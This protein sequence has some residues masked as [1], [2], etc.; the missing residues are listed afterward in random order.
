MIRDLRYAIRSLRQN[1]GF[2]LVAIISLA[3]GIGA[4]AAIFSMADAFVL[5][6]MPVPHPADIVTVESQVRGEGISGLFSFSELSYPDFKDYR[7]R[8]TSFAGLTAMEYSTFGF[9]A[10]PGATPSMKFGQ[11]VTG[12]F[13]QVM[14]VTP[15]LGRGFLPQEDQVEG[16]DAVVVLSHELWKSDFASSPD[17]I[18]RTVFLNNLAFTVVGVAPESFTGPNVLL[19]S[20]LYIP[21]S[22]EVA[23]AATPDQ[24]HREDRSVRG[25]EVQGRLKPG[26][27]VAAAA[28][29]ARLI[30]EQLAKAYPASNRTTSLIV[31]T[32]LRAR[33]HQDSFD[34]ILMGF[35]MALSAVVLLIACANVMNLTL[36]RARGRSREIAVRLAI[37]AGRGR[38]IRQFLTESLVIALLGA[39]AGLLVA[40]AGVG[41]FSQL[42]IPTDIPVIVDLRIDPRVLLFSTFMA[43]G[44]AVVFGLAPALQSTHPDLVPALKS[45]RADGGKRYRFLGRNALV[46]AQVAGSLVL[47]IFASQAYRGAKILLSSPLGFRTDHLLLATLDPSLARYKPDQ[48]KEFY[49]QLLEKARDLTGVKTAALAE[50]IPLMPGGLSSRRV[51]PEGF[52]L[53]PGTEVATVLSNVVSDDYFPTVG[54]PIVEGREFQR[55]DR[56]DSPK[57]AIVNEQFAR[58]YYPQK[59]AV[60]KRFRMNNAEGPLVEIVG[61]A[62]QSK[63]LFPAEPVLEYIYLPLSQT[64]QSQLTL[65]LQTTGPSG[66]SAGA[67]RNLVRSLDPGQPII[68]LRSME[69]YYDQR[70]RGTMDLLLQIVGGLGLVGLAL[71]LVGLYGLIAYSVG[72]RQREIGIRLAIGAEQGKVRGMVLKQGL[73]LAG[74]GS[75]IGLVVA[76]LLGGPATALIGT[77]HFY[78]PLVALV[79]ASML[80]V[81]GMSAYIPA[82][83]ASLLDPNRILRQD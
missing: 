57:V 46:V 12:N 5:R 27:T 74:I 16:R 53:P 2:A 31:E 44:S 65:M 39:A 42:R 37:G 58:K 18:G 24:V 82:R 60:G 45:G 14:G 63:Y 40:E 15:Q 7:D 9:A 19:H 78:L 59:D 34:A 48:T 51:I 55:T 49:R 56:A 50:A 62:K 38:L 83:R 32:D 6:P 11:L 41:L 66:D 3:L 25:L 54:M 68:G 69:D 71:A 23:M 70:A 75:A 17:V 21:L 29:E 8:N 76:L 80:V 64:P 72:L 33:L 61:V 43:L 73:V 26:V 4:N 35:L 20:L 79:V 77:S 10:Q 28:A 30:G 47:L 81:A 13:F 22:M 36:S 67:V 1:P 52:Q